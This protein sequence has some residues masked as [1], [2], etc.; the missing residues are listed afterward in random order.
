MSSCHMQKKNPF[1]SAEDDDKKKDEAPPQS[2]TAG[3]QQHPTSQG[4]KEQAATIA[5]EGTEDAER[6][7]QGQVNPK[8]IG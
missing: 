1:Q 7:R 2:A 5:P 3:K 4:A 8:S 6:Q